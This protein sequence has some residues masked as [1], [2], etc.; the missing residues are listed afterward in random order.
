[1]TNKEAFTQVTSLRSEGAP[2]LPGGVEKGFTEGAW[3]SRMTRTLLGK[4]GHNGRAILER[5][6]PGKSPQCG[7]DMA[8]WKDG[9]HLASW[10]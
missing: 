7:V 5:N 6:Q 9:M 10:H 4:D 3:S 8:Y 2:A 1:M